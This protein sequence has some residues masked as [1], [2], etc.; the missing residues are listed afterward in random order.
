MKIN[1]N[2]KLTSTQTNLWNHN[3]NICDPL[4]WDYVKQININY[5]CNNYLFRIVGYYIDDMWSSYWFVY[6]F[7]GTHWECLN[8]PKVG[9]RVCCH[10]SAMH[11][12]EDKGY[13]RFFSNI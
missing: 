7:G 9:G 10:L 6:K 3:I 11:E 1:Y 2:N 13:Y 8:P 4:I 5:D 12:Y